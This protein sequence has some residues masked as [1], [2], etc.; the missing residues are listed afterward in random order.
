MSKYIWLTGKVFVM[1]RCFYVMEGLILMV[2]NGI[3]GSASIN[4]QFF[5]KR[6]PEDEMIW[7]M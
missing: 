3:F 5:Q 2:E 1:V 6:D 7:H 4:K